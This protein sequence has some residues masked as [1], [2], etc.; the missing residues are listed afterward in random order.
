MGTASLFDDILKQELN[1]H[2]AWLPITNTFEIGDYGVVS[3]GVLVKMGNIRAF[4]VGWTPDAGPP[5]T[6]NFASDDTTMVRAVGNATVQAFPEQDIDASLTIEFRRESSFVVKAA[7]TVSEMQDRAAVADKLSQV[8]QWKSRYRVVSA[9]HVGQHCTIISSKGANSKITLS[10]KANTLKQ[11]GL[12]G[13][14]AGIEVSSAE[15]IGL[16][17]VGETGVVGLSLFKLRWLVGGVDILDAARPDDPTAQ[18]R[19]ETIADWARLDDDV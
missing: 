18:F 17:I 1:I 14:S 9:I 13:A 11:L 5:A 3:D 19:I 7:L 15:R 2:A 4:G 12:A 8:Q 16:N 10:G 6:L